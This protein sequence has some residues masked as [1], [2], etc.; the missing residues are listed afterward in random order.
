MSRAVSQ[1]TGRL[2]RSG[3]L[4]VW[5]LLATVFGDIVEAQGGQA[6]TAA[7]QEIIAD[8]GIGNGALRTAMSRLGRDGW[9]GR[10]RMGKTVWVAL[11]ADAAK[12]SRQAAQVIYAPLRTTQSGPLEIAVAPPDSRKRQPSPPSAIVQYAPDRWSVSLAPG[13]TL[14]PGGADRGLARS[15]AALV[16]GIGPGQLPDWVLD[17]LEIPALSRALHDLAREI[18]TLESS[19]RGNDIPAGPALAARILLV[20]QWRRIALRLPPLPIAAMPADWPE[21]TCRAS[22]GRLY[23]RLLAPS[24]DR[25]SGI[26]GLGAPDSGVIAA[27]FDRDSRRRAVDG[28]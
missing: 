3:H 15:D 25:L 22:V 5:S 2:R 17:R 20:H 26:G 12:E 8:L 11:S 7:L 21:A 1:W 28:E 6:T 27:R 13:V 24:L 10:R 23:R 9:I 14:R 18:V 19:M 16:A 4:R